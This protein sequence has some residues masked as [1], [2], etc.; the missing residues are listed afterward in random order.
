MMS[1][2]E[3]SA[4]CGETV[5]WVR[6]ICITV[7]MHHLSGNTCEE[8]R[9]KRFRS[10]GIGDSLKVTQLVSSRSGSQSKCPEPDGSAL[11][12]LCHEVALA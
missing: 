7:C 1:L 8:G 3:N 9:G 10:Q 6:S 12:V 5:L 11:F 2:L 4:L